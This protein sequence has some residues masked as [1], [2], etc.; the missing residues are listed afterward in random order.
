M[1]GMDEGIADYE[2]GGMD[3]E[4]LKTEHQHMNW[5]G[6]YKGTAGNPKQ[7]GQWRR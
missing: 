3:K 6:E 1:G 5:R 2:E 7:H 4:I